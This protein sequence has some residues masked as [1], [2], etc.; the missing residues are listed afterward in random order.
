MIC[1]ISEKIIKQEVFVFFQIIY[2]AVVLAL[3]EMV[4]ELLYKEECFQIVGLSM[5]VHNILGKG[6][7]EIVYKDA[8]EIELK[9]NN[10]VH[11]REAPFYILYEDHILAHE[12]VADFFVFDSVIVEE[13]STSIIHA[14]TFRQTLNYLKASE[15]KLGIIINF[16]CDRLQFK[17]I[18]CSY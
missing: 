18:V 7:K 12:F 2:R 11:K 16:G 6:F 4:N 15:I 13:K 8:L 9:R 5:K 1:F 14:D 17:R 10:I 3:Q